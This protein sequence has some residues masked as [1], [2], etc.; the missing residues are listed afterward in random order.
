MRMKGFSSFV[1]GISAFCG[2]RS[3]ITVTF[4]HSCY[5]VFLLCERLVTNHVFVIRSV[6]DWEGPEALEKRNSESG[7]VK[8]VNTRQE[9]VAPTE[10]S[11]VHVEAEERAES[12]YD[13]SG[14]EYVAEL[15]S[16]KGKGKVCVY[17]R[18]HTLQVLI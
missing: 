9:S 13:G 15:A 7:T 12:S 5:R 11:E 1:E 18:F 2:L 10:V 3:S 16:P 8:M 6:V 4:L 17:D 14:D